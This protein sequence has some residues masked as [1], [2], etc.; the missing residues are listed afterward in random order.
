MSKFVHPT[1]DFTQT[2]GGKLAWLWCLLFGPLYF[3][4][5]GNW[6]MVFIGLFC[7]LFT[8]GLSWL[9][10]PFFVY[11]INRKEL[12]LRGFKEVK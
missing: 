9:V 1:N 12:M 4:S 3:A 2:N 10:F 5:K 11:K 8:I 7:G 6:R